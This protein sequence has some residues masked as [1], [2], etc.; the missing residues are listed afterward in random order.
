MLARLRVVNPV[1][2]LGKDKR[3]PVLTRLWA[4]R[5]QHTSRQHEMLA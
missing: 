3:R 2:I 4:Y 1:L 5:P